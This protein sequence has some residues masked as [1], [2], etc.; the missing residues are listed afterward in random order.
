[1]DELDVDD[2]NECIETEKKAGEKRD[3]VQ[4]RVG[5]IDKRLEEINDVKKE[6]GKEVK[7][8]SR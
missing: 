8:I 1:M 2:S 6:K 3:A 5:E 4:A 7:K